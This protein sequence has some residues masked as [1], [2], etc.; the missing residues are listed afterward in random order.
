MR[1]PKFELD[2]KSRLFEVLHGQDKLTCRF[3]GD[4]GG[5]T[6]EFDF[7]ANGF[8]P[9]VFESYEK[10]NKCLAKMLHSAGNEAVIEIDAANGVLS[11]LLPVD[12]SV[13]KFYPIVENVHNK[14]LWSNLQRSNRHFNVLS[15]IS[16]CPRHLAFILGELNEAGGDPE[17]ASRISVVFQ[18]YYQPINSTDKKQSNQMFFFH[19]NQF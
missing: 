8:Y 11:S 9:E 7:Y 15:R 2:R 5:E 19:E 18:T 13:K 12:S 17:H 4:S 6:H 14:S 1:N 10:L 3:D 16:N